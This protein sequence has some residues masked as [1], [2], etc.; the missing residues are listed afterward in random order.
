MALVAPSAPPLLRHQVLGE[1][2]AFAARQGALRVWVW[3]LLVLWV[4]VGVGVGVGRMRILRSPQLLKDVLGGVA[5]D[6]GPEGTDRVQAEIDP[7]ITVQADW[8]TDTLDP[9]ITVQTDWLVH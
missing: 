4:G 1:L 5:A 3:V 7:D 9:D 2:A 6:L 8:L